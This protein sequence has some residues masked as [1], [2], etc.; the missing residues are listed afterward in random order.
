MHYAFIIMHYALNYAF[1][2]MHYALNYALNYALIFALS[3]LRFSHNVCQTAFFFVS[4]RAVWIH[5]ALNDS[6]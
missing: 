5:I 4:L 1:I 3:A 2:I 6:I